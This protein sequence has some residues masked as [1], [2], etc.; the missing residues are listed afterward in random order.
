[1]IQSILVYTREGRTIYSWESKLGSLSYT[2]K[3][4]VPGFFSAINSI[5]GEIFQGRIQRLILE[6]KTIV[7]SGKKY[8]IGQKLQWVLISLTVDIKDNDLLID[9]LVRSLIDI[10]VTKLDLEQ[11]FLVTNKNLDNEIELFLQKKLFIRSRKKIITSSVLIFIS[12]LIMS[13][14]YSSIRTQQ[15]GIDSSNIVSF[16][17]AISI[18]LLLMIPS[19][20]LAGS[21]KISSLIGILMSTI[22]SVFSYWFITQYLVETPFFDYIGSYYVYIV[23]CIL[24]GF[25][26][27]Y[28]GGAIIDRYF[29]N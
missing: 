9:S 13:L 18:G 11:E 25:C 14:V 24:M 10:I 15:N 19:S 20:S 16:S 6:D 7:L 23:F 22:G 12:T 8:K 4:L 17:F 27:G 3:I 26:S 29:L 5:V 21:K 2:N 1:M 28:L